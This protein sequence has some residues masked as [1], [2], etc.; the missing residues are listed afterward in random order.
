MARV[1]KITFQLRRGLHDKWIEENP[2]LSE[3][4]PAFETDTF[5]LKIGDGGYIRAGTQ[6]LNGVSTTVELSD[7]GIKW[8]FPVGLPAYTF[9][10]FAG[11]GSGANLTGTITPNK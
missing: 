7:N 10:R 8:A 1:I 11:Y 5:R 2:I 4:E 6:S 9:L 3:G